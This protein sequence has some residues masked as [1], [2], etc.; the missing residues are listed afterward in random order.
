[1]RDYDASAARHETALHQ[2]IDTLER[3]IGETETSRPKGTRNPNSA[4]R[5]QLPT[6]RHLPPRREAIQR[7][8]EKGLLTEEEYASIELEPPR[9]HDNKSTGLE[10]YFLEAL[11]EPDDDCGPEIELLEEP[12]EA[13]T[14]EEEEAE[15]IR[16][17]ALNKFIRESQDNLAK[18]AAPDKAR[19]MDGPSFLSAGLTCLT[20]K[21]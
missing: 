13:L 3:Y 20:P 5:P 14:P 7:A 2:I 8:W 4:S 21:Y 15:A 18:L 16:F 19:G 17:E 11:E 12:D 6:V 9:L 10:G 1:M